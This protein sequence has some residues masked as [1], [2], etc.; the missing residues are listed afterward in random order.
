[1]RNIR[2]LQETMERLLSDFSKLRMPLMLGEESVW[3]PL[4]DVYE[5]GDEFVVRMEIAG[6]DPEDIRV[7]LDER[8]L[9][10]KGVRRDPTPTGKKHFHKM[11]ITVGPFERNIEIPADFRISSVEAHYE[12]GFLTIRIGKGAKEFTARDRIVPVERGA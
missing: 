8:I 9:I 4:T 10:I 2:H 3:L 6:M 1:M 7:T 11:E 5:T 12:K